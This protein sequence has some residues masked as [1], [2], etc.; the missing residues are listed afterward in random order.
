MS[1]TLF[2]ILFFLTFRFFQTKL[3]KMTQNCTK[4]RSVFFS[5]FCS[6]Y[7]A[8]AEQRVPVRTPLLFHIILIPF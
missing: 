3:E 4:Y 2:Q 5:T 7:L 6:L 1:D 8:N